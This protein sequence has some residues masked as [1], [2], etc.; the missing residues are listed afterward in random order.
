LTSV[1]FARFARW[2]CLGAFLAVLT[3]CGDNRVFTYKK[4]NPG[5]VYPAGEASG[6]PTYGVGLRHRF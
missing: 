6:E 3:G 4:D 1:S 5:G 2:A